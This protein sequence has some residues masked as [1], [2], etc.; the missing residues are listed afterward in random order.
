MQSRLFSYMVGDP[1]AGNGKYCLWLD[2]KKHFIFFIVVLSITLFLIA[3]FR[4]NP[5]PQKMQ[6]QVQS[7]TR[8]V[9]GKG[10]VLSKPLLLESDEELYK[11]IFHAQKSARWDLANASIT[12]LSNKILLSDILAERYLSPDYNTSSAEIIAWLKNYPDNLKT[13]E[14]LEMAGNKYPEVFANAPKMGKPVR[15]QGYGDGNSEDIRFDDNTTAKKL[16]LSGLEAW[17]SNKK[18]EAANYFSNLTRQK[19]L[20]DWQDAAANFWAYRAFSVIGDKNKADYYLTQAADNPR[21]FYGILANK[22]LRKPLKLDTE[23]IVENSSEIQEYWQKEKIQRII[24]YTESGLNERAEAQIRSIFPSASK[25]EKWFLLAL[26]SKLNLASVQISMAKQLETSERQLDLLKYP[27]PAWHPLGGHNIDPNLVYALIRQESGFYSAA[28]SS[29]GALGLMQLMPQTAKKM[30][31]QIYD[32]ASKDITANFSEPV[33]NITLGERYVGNLLENS[34]V[35]G[36]LFYM[37]TA[38]NA[39]PKRLK[40]WQENIAYNDDP[41]LFI[42]SIPYPETRSYV[43]QVMTNYWIYLELDGKQSQSVTAL[44]QGNWPTYH[45]LA[46]SVADSGRHRHDG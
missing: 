30:H 10:D 1:M 45:P 42:E 39:G 35:D 43:M 20:S 41:L 33:L 12:R 23:N 44:L 21:V 31:T 2:R 5:P 19:S 14:M 8:I 16:W 29:G 6:A 4:D 32:I 3:G 15:L 25:Q 22:Q 7:A 17:R 46:T 40:D 36:N 13:A 37:L 24:A 28:T 11:Q 18:Q 38:Y 9:A 26:A 27:V 34:L